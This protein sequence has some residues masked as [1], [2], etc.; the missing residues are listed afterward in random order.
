MPGLDSLCD[1]LDWEVGLVPLVVCEKPET[2]KVS[3]TGTASPTATEK[4]RES[5]VQ[6]DGP[7]VCLIDG[8]CQELTLLDGPCFPLKDRVNLA[9]FRY[10]L[11]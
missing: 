2:C 3:D 9:G 1:A 10:E 4:D 5:L 6:A 11:F 7:A 8:G